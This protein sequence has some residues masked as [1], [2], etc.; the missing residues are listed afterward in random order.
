MFV[1]LA[2]FSCS[3]SAAHIVCEAA[4]ADKGGGG[5]GAEWREGVSVCWK[6]AENY[7]E[8]FKELPQANTLSSCMRQIWRTVKE[9][10]AARATKN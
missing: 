6:R 4:A 1:Q 3:F 8:Y 7:E 5:G 10:L 9:S 2:F